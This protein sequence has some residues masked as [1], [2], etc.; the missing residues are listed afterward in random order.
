MNSIP[1]VKKKVVP[2]KTIIES[3]KQMGKKTGGTPTIG[4]LE[5]KKKQ[6]STNR[7][8]GVRPTSSTETVD[9]HVKPKSAA[10]KS[11]LENKRSTTN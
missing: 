8:E 2:K 5:V 7:I 11:L 9:S 4:S 6:K 1:S 10:H 3:R